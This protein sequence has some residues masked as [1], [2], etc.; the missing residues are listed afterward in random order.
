MSFPL[1]CFCCLAA[2][3]PLSESVSNMRQSEGSDC[4]GSLKGFLARWQWEGG[5]DEGGEG[6]GSARIKFHIPTPSSFCCASPSQPPSP[7]HNPPPHPLN[8]ETEWLRWRKK[9]CNP[10]LSPYI[11][12]RLQQ[13]LWSVEKQINSDFKSKPSPL[14]C[15]QSTVSARERWSLGVL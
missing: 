3:S 1:P 12:L 7:S 6:R 8:L 2:L 9:T 15:T 14:E 10:T 4:S 13:P 11:H 5:G